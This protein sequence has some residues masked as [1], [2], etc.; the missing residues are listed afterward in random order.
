M[1]SCDLSDLEETEG[2]YRA[3]A[4]R[5]GAKFGD[6]MMPL[7][8]AVT[9]S[10]VSPP[11]FESIRLIGISTVAIRVARALKALAQDQGATD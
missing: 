5:L 10:R 6:L 8:V 7:R 2:R 4:E 9:G 11:L 1:P 3:E